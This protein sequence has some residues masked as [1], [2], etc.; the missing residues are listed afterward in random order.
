MSDN[1]RPHLRDCQ[2]CHTKGDDEE[3]ILFTME[4]DVVDQFAYGYTVRCCNCGVSITDEYQSEAVRIWNGEPR[5]QDEGDA[6]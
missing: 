3:N 5:P 1:I 2:F 4:C 6:A